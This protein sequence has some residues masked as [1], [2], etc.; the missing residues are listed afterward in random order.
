MKAYLVS[1]IERQPAY[2]YLGAAVPTASGF[3]V[4]VEQATKIGA[5]LSITIGI[6]VGFTTWR[7]QR[8]QA[9]RIEAELR[10]LAADRKP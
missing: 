7:V 4:L 6:V 2:G 8:M 9:R 3:W 10:Q 5:L 1:L